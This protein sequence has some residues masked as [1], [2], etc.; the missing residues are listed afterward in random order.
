M[1]QTKDQFLVYL[2]KNKIIHTN[3]KT[4]KVFRWFIKNKV[5]LYSPKEIHGYIDNKGYYIIHLSFNK[6][7]YLFRVR[8]VIWTSVHG[9]K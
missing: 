4:G 6:K 7:E 1:K 3:P 5:P 9:N 8:R 2:L